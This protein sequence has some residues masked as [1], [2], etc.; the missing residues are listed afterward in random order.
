MAVA[1]AARLPGARPRREWGWTL[2]AAAAA[3]GGPFVLGIVLIV[4]LVFAWPAIVWNGAAFFTTYTWNLGNLYGGAPVVRGGYAAAAGAHYGML[5]FLLGTLLSSAL[6]LILAAPIGIGVAFCL[7]EF[8]G[9]G[10]ARALGFFIELLA[11][12]P[13]VLFGLWGFVVLVPW[14]QRT[15]GPALAGVLGFIPIFRGPVRT[16]AGL[17]ASGMVLGAMILPI[18]AA[19]SRDALRAVPADLRDQGRALGLTEWEVARDLVWRVAAPG[20][21]ASCILALGRALGETMAV[22]MVSGNALNY[23]P[24]TIYSPI[25]TIASTIVALLDSAMTDATG[26]ATHALAEL[27]VVLFV[28]TVAVN[29]VAPVVVR[30]VGQHRGWVASRVGGR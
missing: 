23:L 21:V 17:L 24:G 13:S 10:A 19:V 20:V 30:R 7:S 2:L 25:A 22:L 26:M 16:G 18:I 8:A 5:G 29:L 12:V 1:A 11:G 3:A 27:A 9:R 4:L 6:A 14:I 28:V 15:A